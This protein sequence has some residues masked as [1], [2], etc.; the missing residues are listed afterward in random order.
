MMRLGS[1]REIIYPIEIVNGRDINAVALSSPEG[2]KIQ[3][4]S[5]AS[6][7]AE[8]EIAFI[9]GHEEA[10]LDRRHI[11]KEKDLFNA[12][13]LKMDEIANDRSMGV[14]SRALRMVFTGIAT[15]AAV[16]PI[17]RELELECDMAAKIR[18]L[19][20]GYDQ[21]DVLR[22]LKRAGYRQGSYFDL[23]PTPQF[24]LKMLKD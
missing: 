22:L 23:H 15:F 7:L 14:L 4:T 3:I 24:R 6:R 2:C 19:E 10:H 21:N 9:I 17:S 16:P 13:D 5:A 11:N 8:G 1:V 12:T 18:M 20:A